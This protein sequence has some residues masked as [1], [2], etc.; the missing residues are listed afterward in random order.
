[1]A[2]YFA[3]FAVEIILLMP[4]RKSGGSS[5]LIME[6]R[7]RVII[8]SV[9]VFILLHGSLITRLNDLERAWGLS[10]NIAQ[11]VIIS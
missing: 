7:I 4:C 5:S 1:M 9:Q 11:A 2:L 6:V 3:S 8:D 10:V